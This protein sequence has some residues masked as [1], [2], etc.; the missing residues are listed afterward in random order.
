MTSALAGCFVLFVGCAKDAEPSAPEPAASQGSEATP[1]PQPALNP[2]A[3]PAEEPVA[4]VAPAPAIPAPDVALSDG[5]VVGIVQAINAGEI[6]QAQ[7]AK[8]KA[9]DAR[10]KKFADHM[11]TQHT[12]SQ[13]QLGKMQSAAAES[14]VQSDLKVASAADLD[15]L[16]NTE[17]ADFDAVYVNSQV[18]QHKAALD[19]LTN[20]LVPAASD[21]KLQ[22]LLESTRATVEQH[23]KSANEL[24]QA[25]QSSTKAR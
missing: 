23:L 11:I 14:S 25:L 24:Q 17:A 19:M 5:Q 3:A 10:V 20:R 21:A 15:T 18:K 8:S 12:D 6:D 1:E 2:A 7:L 16:K 13:K 22:A 4:A 9:K